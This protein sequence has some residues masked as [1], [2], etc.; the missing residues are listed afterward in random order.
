MSVKAIGGGVVSDWQQLIA[1]QPQ[2]S[3]AHKNSERHGTPRRVCGA[4]TV[5]QAA[6]CGLFGAGQQNKSGRHI[7]C[8]F[9]RPGRPGRFISN[10][11]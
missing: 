4:P 5:S 10:T 11:S 7:A 2:G 6:A 8:R 1:E 3:D 9:L